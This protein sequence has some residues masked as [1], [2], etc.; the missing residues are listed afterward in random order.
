MTLVHA[1]PSEPSFHPLSAG[2]FLL[3]VMGVIVGAGAGIGAAA[4]RLGLGVAIGALVGIPA[5]VGAVILRY[6]DRV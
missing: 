6:R 2:A 4:G 1:V 3:S 5:A